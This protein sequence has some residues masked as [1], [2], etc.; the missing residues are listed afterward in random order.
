[1]YENDNYKIQINWK[2][3]ILK[4][5]AIIIIILLI[6][7]LFPMP[8]LDTFYNKVFNDNLN[9][10]KSAAENY[11][12][13]DKL[14]EKTGAST[15]IKLDDMID[16]KIIMNFVD[17][18]NNSCNGSNSYAQVTK[19]ESNT[20][21]LK[22]QLSCD[23]KTDYVLE[24][25]NNIKTN[26]TTNSTAT[27]TDE[28]TITK[29]NS[30]DDA[31]DIIDSNANYDKDGNKI[32]Y[33]YKK[34]VTKTSSSYS[35]PTGYVLD[36]NT[37]YKYETGETINATPLYFNDITTTNDAK[38]NN[39]GSYTVT[40]IPNK[41]V[42]KQDKVCP[43]GY[44]LNGNICY[45]YQSVNVNPGSS[46]YSCP[47]GYS[48]NGSTCTKTIN[49]SYTNNSSTYY[50]C[51]DG[52]QPNGTSCPKYTTNT[53]YSTSCSCP[54]GYNPSGS[55]C[56]KYVS[57]SY[58][59]QETSIWSNPT[60]SESTIRLTEYNNGSSRRVLAHTTCTIRGCHYIYYNSYLKKSYSCPNG[61]NPSGTMCYTS[62]PTYSNK[63]CT[64]TPHTTTQVSYYQANK[65]ENGG[66]YYYCP[67]GYTLNGTSCTQ[68]KDATAHTTDT[69]YSCPT[70]YVKEG[71]TCYQYT[72]V[73]NNITYKY[74]C[75]NGYTKNGDDK[76]TTCSKT[77]NSNTTYYCEDANA[78]LVDTKCLKVVKGGLKGYSC[79][80][81]YIL[82]NDK[83]VKKTTEC[84]KPEEVT[85]T[86][87]NYEYKWSTENSL[88]GWTQTGKTKNTDTINNDYEK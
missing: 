63:V 54:L 23:D 57:G 28:H 10:V 73:T 45:K 6:I 27:D 40:I 77:I 51:D 76:S 84:T 67:A 65:H 43:T 79:P 13:A 5:A 33:Q 12:T 9:S 85:N 53:T 22:V 87:T 80:D 59:A 31:E 72:E 7:W 58:T 52:S 62:T 78:T 3:I 29:N 88:E 24:N 25:L 39:S 70:G 11:F 82:N 20:Y 83:C 75:P 49:A 36:N 8:K 26:T 35:C 81:N 2:N 42:D 34:A 38:K 37:C 1:M 47:D 60:T 44:T 71:S 86:S 50:T 21:V 4:L 30:E 56:V 16:K 14:P 66:T 48:Q 64:Q 55:S 32:E 15:T 17:K 68:N 69:T 74:T 46:S 61:G 19:T 41:E 18:N